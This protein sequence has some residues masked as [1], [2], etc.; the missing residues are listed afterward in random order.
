MIPARRFLFLRHGQTDWNLEGR[1][2]G[3]SD[4]ALNETGLMQARDAADGLRGVGVDQIVSSPLIRA[5]KTAA[6][7]AECLS[8]PV[9]VE[10]DLRER[11]FGSFDGLVV[12]DVKRRHGLPLNEPSHRIFPS[13][14]EP[15]A[16][17]LRRCESVI[18]NWLAD[19]PDGETT[20]FV[21]HDGVF[22]AL[23]EILHGASLVSRHATPYVFEPGSGGW[24]VAEMPG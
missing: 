1:F 20:L 3:V 22:R 13:D 16:Q 19:R 4:I 5:L 24:T 2:Q 7:V 10:A 12:A 8:L 17:T 14:A 11:D 18:G 21:A 9:Y 15:W 23:S 6:I